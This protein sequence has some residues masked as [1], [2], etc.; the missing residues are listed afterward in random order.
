MK[1]Y[2]MNTNYLIIKNYLKTPTRTE[3]MRK[4]L[5]GVNRY[6]FRIMLIQNEGL[7]CMYNTDTLD[8][9]QYI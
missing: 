5:T 2:K 6:L 4:N 9:L 1:H 8:R 3:L 7:I